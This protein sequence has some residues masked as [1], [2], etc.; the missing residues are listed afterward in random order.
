MLSSEAMSVFIEEQKSMKLLYKTW[1][2]EFFDY[3]AVLKCCYD[4]GGNTAIKM[5]SSCDQDYESF[6]AEG[7]E[8][9]F[10]AAE[11]VNWKTIYYPDD[12]GEINDMCE[13]DYDIWFLSSTDMTEYYRTLN[14]LYKG[15]ILNKEEYNKYKNEMLQM[16]RRYLLNGE[17]AYYGSLSFYLRTKINHKYA[18]SI[19]IY[20]DMNCCGSLFEISCGVAT[21]FDMYSLKLK[22]LRKKYYNK[23]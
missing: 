12:N 6:E 3:L 19:S 8:Y 11:K 2:M 4:E 1:L 10:E 17:T 13:P 22:E 23:G 14:E 5:Y 18:S 20:I 9:M 16:T 15:G 21:L 7:F